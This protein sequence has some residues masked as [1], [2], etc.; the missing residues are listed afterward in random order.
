MIYPKYPFYQKARDL[1]LSTQV[2]QVAKGLEKYDEPFTPQHWSPR[3]LLDHALEES[4]DMTHYLV[5][6][7][8]LL[9]DK[10]ALIERLQK[11]NEI[12][13]K[14]LMELT[15]TPYDADWFSNGTQNI[16]L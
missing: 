13:C 14:Q 7:K 8:E 4:V 6:L 1:W 12:L 2:R 16:P 11:E 3:E 15:K 10:D 5:G 9:D